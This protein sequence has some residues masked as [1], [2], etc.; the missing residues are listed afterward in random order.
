MI[1][2]RRSP[3][4]AALL[5]VVA[6]A[7]TGC[8]P[9]SQTVTITIHYTAFDP[10]EIEVPR[11]V[12]I[13]FVLVNEDPIDHEWLSGDAAVHDAHRLGTPGS[14]G[15]VP[16]EV[17]VPALERA[18]TTIPFDEPGEF[19]YICHL[20]GHEAYGMVGVLTVRD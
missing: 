17:T 2:F 4:V 13:T 7:A 6:A 14:H 18:E 19:A 8:G 3:V 5:L 10:A 15:E 12:P 9:G 16:P 20:P 1:G 11:G